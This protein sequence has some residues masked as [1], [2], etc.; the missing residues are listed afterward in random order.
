MIYFKHILYNVVN[1]AINTVHSCVFN[2][3]L[4]SAKFACVVV[5]Y[6]NL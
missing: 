5:A 4:N 6:R 3:Y 1:L 2:A